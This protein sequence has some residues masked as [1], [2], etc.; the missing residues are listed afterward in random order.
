MN[1]LDALRRWVVGLI[2]V[3]AVAMACGRIASTELL[4]EPSLHRNAEDPGTARVWPKARPRPMPTFSSN[5]R[6]RWATVRALVD[7]GTFAVGQRDLRATRASAAAPIGQTDAVAVATL[8]VAGFQVRT[9]DATNTGIIFLDGYKSVDKVL[10]QDTQAYYSSKPPLLA[11]LVAGLYWLLEKLSALVYALFGGLGSASGDPQQW[12]LASHPNEVVRTILLLINALPFAGY[13]A[14]MARVANVWG[15]TEPGKLFVVVAAAFG[16]LV[17]P[18]LI[19]FNNHTIATFSVMAAWF[20]LLRIWRQISAGTWGQVRWYDYVTAAFFSAFAASNEMPGLAFVTAVFAILLWYRPG[21]TLRWFVPAAALPALAF[22]ATNYAAL[23]QWR[24]VQS[25][26]ESPWY[27]YEG[28]HWSKAKLNEGKPTPGIDFAR[29]KESRATYA[30]HLLLGHHGLFALTPIW[31]L[32][33]AA[34]LMGSFR[35]RTLWQAATHP[36]EA[37]PDELPWFVQPLGLALTVVVVGFY[38]TR[39]EAAN[40]G[41]WTN[42]PRWLMWLTPIW[43]TCLLP[44]ADRLACCARGRTIAYMLLGLSVFSAHYD[45]W[46]PWRHPWLYDFLMECGWPG[47]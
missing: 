15:R 27:L 42:G 4:F 10:S 25:D 38:L 14:L 6:S 40:Y 7:E 41:G 23:G 26:F 36:A 16:T 34:M 9:D 20:A 17:T 43:L 39:G 2:I 3:T 5:D 12:T 22:F 35:V 8:A 1:E 47:Y 31:L 18:F 32:A 21:P 11:T 33:A 29:T 19:T 28:S 37:P 30:F 45:L 24:P 46:N 44:V 13:L